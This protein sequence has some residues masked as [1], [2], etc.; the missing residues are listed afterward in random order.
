M[1]RSHQI[2]DFEEILLMLCFHFQTKACLMTDDDRVE[3]F[4]SL[5]E[6]SLLLVCTEVLPCIAHKSCVMEDNAPTLLSTF[7]L[8]RNTASGARSCGQKCRG[9]MFQDT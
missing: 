3:A 7:L 6:T 8:D 4:A 2:H 5:S 1:A 9:V